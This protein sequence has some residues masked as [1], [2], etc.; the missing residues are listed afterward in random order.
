MIFHSF[1]FLVFFVVVLAA[2]WRLTHRGQNVLLLAASY[3]FYGWV[4]P[5]F[6]GLIFFTSVIDFWAARGIAEWPGGRKFMLGLS[7]GANLG[8]LAFFKYFNFFADNVHVALAA[9]GI[10]VSPPVLR[11]ILPVGISFYTFQALSYTLDVYYGRLQARRDFV[12]F[13]TF[14]ALFPQLVAGP[15][16]RASHLLPQV[17]QPRTFS[18]AAARDGVALAVWGFFKKLVIADN[19]GIIANKIFSLQEPAFPLLWAGVFAF[20]IQIYA[21]FS[22]YTDIARGTARCFGFSLMRNFNHPYL[23]T[24]P[25]DFWRRWHISLSTW[26]RDYLF[27]PIGGS[28]GSRWRTARNI[29][30]TFVVSGLWHGASWNFVLWGAYHGALVTISRFLPQ[31][32]LPA[33][34]RVALLPL[35]VAGTFALVLVGWF[36][37]RETDTTFLVR[38]LTLSPFGVP[39][40][41]WMAGGY[42][43][44]LAFVYSL[45]L[46]LE[47]VWAEWLRPVVRRRRDD[48]APADWNWAGLAGRAVLVAAAVALIA[49]LRSRQSLDFI[50]F[51]F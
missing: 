43:F 7:I 44:L 19:V 4:H 5:W 9:L 41:D 23:A 24:G 47:S 33:V 21:D 2:Y 20:A 22:A 28:R 14:V 37:F 50:Y 27:I 26:F 15:I 16:E 46:W 25:A 10:D 40:A 35:R 17:E 31:V 30:I 1:E 8:L 36:L 3:V 39:Q 13:A 34:V 38:G 42:L 6:V 11:V 32:A 51:Q 29:M 18:M 49:V 45:P 48:E 12:G